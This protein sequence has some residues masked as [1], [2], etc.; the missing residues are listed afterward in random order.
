MSSR[1]QTPNFWILR[2]SVAT[3]NGTCIKENGKKYLELYEKY[4]DT[5]QLVSTRVPQF[6]SEKNT[7]LQK[8][9]KKQGRPAPS[10][11]YRFHV[12]IHNVKKDQ[13]IDVSNGRC[14]MVDIEKYFS[15]AEKN[16]KHNGG[17][18]PEISYVDIA[19]EIEGYWEEGVEQEFT[20]LELVEVVIMMWW[21]EWGW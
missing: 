21:K 11:N 17:N 5:I 2:D 7:Q 14:M 13:F 15:Q 3:L 19:K 1:T 16:K 20:K 18:V 6:K 12:M 4:G 8:L 10:E 9:W